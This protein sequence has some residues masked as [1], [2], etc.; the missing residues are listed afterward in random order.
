[1]EPFDFYIA[2][3]SWGSDGKTRPVLVYFLENN[4]V[5]VFPVTTQYENKSNIVQ[6]NYFKISDW[7]Q[8]GLHKQSY[9]DTGV[10]YKFSITAFKD[11]API[12]KLTDNDKIRLLEFLA[13]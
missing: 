13:E 10:P 12:G 2:Y 6:A 3:V 9:V 4:E 11:K 8:A 5:T 1:M 7:A